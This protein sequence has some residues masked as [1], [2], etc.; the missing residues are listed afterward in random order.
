MAAKAPLKSIRIREFRGSSK[1][2]SL[3][4]DSKKRLTLVYG[5]NGSGKT[6]I[7]DAFDFIGNRK[8]GSLTNRGLGQVHP[9]WSTVGKTSGSILVELS[10]DGIDWTAQV[11]G[12]EVIVSPSDKVMPK[13]EVLRRASIQQLVQ[14][15]PKERY[16]ALRPF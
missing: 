9:Y 11:Q 15:E 12:R 13:I 3:A 5:E 16:S 10:V 6:T 7:C 8:V 4:F 2:F 14:E 1:D